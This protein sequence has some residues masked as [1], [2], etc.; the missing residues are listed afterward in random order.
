MRDRP[1]SIQIPIVGLDQWGDV[2]HDNVK[3]LSEP[4]DI[5]AFGVVGTKGTLDK[6]QQGIKL[7]FHRTTI[8]PRHTRGG[9]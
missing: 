1:I 7:G 2:D 5:E 8:F 3:H 6:N 4:V 9:L